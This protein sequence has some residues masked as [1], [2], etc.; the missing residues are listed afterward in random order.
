MCAENISLSDG[1]LYVL[2]IIGSNESSKSYKI[3]DL[4]GCEN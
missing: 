1:E 4:I 3:D 2:K